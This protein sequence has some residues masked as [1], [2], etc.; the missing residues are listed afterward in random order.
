MKRLLN[1]LLVFSMVFSLFVVTTNE[2]NA[3]ESISFVNEYEKVGQEIK[4][5]TSALEGE[6]T[7]K[8]SVDGKAVSTEATYTPS[9]NDENK[10]IEV[11]VN[12]GTTDYVAKT[13]LSKLPVIYID[14][15][16]GATVTSKDVYLDSQLTMQGNDEWNSETT[17]L[18]VGASEIKGRGNST[19]GLPKKPY[20]LKF[21]KGIDLFGYGKSKHWVLLANYYDTTFLRNKIGY[22]LAG[23][24]DI[25][26]MQSILVD[27]VMNGEYVGNY[28]FCE[29]VRIDDERVEVTDW[30]GIG[31]DAAAAIVEANDLGDDALDELEGTMAENFSW[32]DTDSIQ[33]NNVTYKVSDYIEYPDVS[34]GY[35]LEMDTNYDEVSKFRTNDNVPIMFKGPEFANTS[36]SMMNYVK[37]YIQA[38]E[39]AV[40][41]PN[42]TAEHEDT[43]KHYTELFDMQSLVDNWLIQELFFN[44][45]FMK[46]STYMYKDHGELF[47]MGPVWDL[48]WASGAEQSA[49]KPYNQ[50]QTTYFN[51]DCQRDQWYKYMAKDPYFIKLAQERYLE[52]R[53]SYIVEMMND[54][55][56]YSEQIAVSAQK[57]LDIW[58]KGKNYESEMTKFKTWMNNRLEFL[59]DK[60]AD[61]DTFLN[62]FD[63]S[64]SKIEV[65]GEL[66]D[67]E[68]TYHYAAGQGTKLTLT[69]SGYGQKAEVWV[70]NQKVDE[71][72]A[73]D[74]KVSYELE[75]EE[76]CVV[77][78][79]FYNNDVL[80]SKAYTSISTQT[81]DRTLTGIEITAPTKVLY[82]LGEELDATGLLVKAIFDDGTYKYINDYTISGF[83]SQTI[84]EKE[85]T[86]NYGGFTQTFSV[87]VI[88]SPAEIHMSETDITIDTGDSYELKVT[89][90]NALQTDVTWVSDNVKVAEVYGGKVVGVSEGETTIRAS[91]PDGQTVTCKVTV[92]K[93]AS[94]MSD[95]LDPNRMEVIA[96]NEDYRDPA[97][98]VL[99]GNEASVWHTNWNPS[100]K[101]RDDHYLEFYLDE[102]A[103][104]SG[105]K[106]LP[107]QDNSN[108]GVIKT[109]NLYVKENSDEGAEWI[110]VVENGELSNSKDWQLVT[111]EATQASEIRLEVID[112]L[113][114]QSNVF[115]SAAEIRFVG[116]FMSDVD[117]QAL[118]LAFDTLSAVD[119]QEYVVDAY[120]ASFSNALANAKEVLDNQTATQ[121]EVDDAVEFLRT[122]YNNLTKRIYI[123]SVAFKDKEL[124]LVKSDVI[125]LEVE[126]NPENTTEDKTLTFVSSDD[127]VVRVVGNI[128]VAVGEGTA[129]VTV[130]SANGKTD[131][132]VITVEK[133]SEPESPEKPFPFEDVFKG[134]W[135][136]E[137]V[138]QAYQLGLMTGATETLF[139][140]TVSMN[141]GMVAIVLHRMEGS[142][143]VAYAPIFPDV[144]D[145]QYFTTAV[146]WAKQTGIITGYNNGT[147]MP[148]KNVT[149]EEMATMI[150]RFAKYK[151][152]DVSSSK[153]ITYF[154]DYAEIST[155]AKAPIE[156][157]VENG[158]LSGKFEGTKVD[159]LG[160][161]SRAECA[162]MLVQAYKVIYK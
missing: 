105:I 107:R 12:D 38:F 155:Y 162:K 159:P 83:D 59:D 138:D 130:T 67:N 91:L 93:S 99:D 120:L 79:Y 28:Q 94:D 121:K 103:V 118:Q 104:I 39:D 134:Q 106:L 49:A 144:Y 111:F 113:S 150:Q 108:N 11:I 112:A 54:I 157:C 37:T 116:S 72:E 85:V 100:T 8:W 128:A 145:K 109:F 153:D 41:A 65:S 15:E 53:D 110:K 31:E 3:A 58:R 64:M 25:P 9:A 71:V 81:V 86:V 16:N 1:I 117:K 69:A 143:K 139:K 119:T 34:G 6:L 88:D 122:A 148:L 17:K 62:E 70:N 102:P 29:H 142:E 4:V 61:F 97:E 126:I 5:D 40:K 92:V 55:D 147:F 23:D 90:V 131:T 50:W 151:G 89:L 20:R 98:N 51:A 115:S 82:K 141:R 137:Y 43:V 87:E 35:L 63:A 84:G 136:Y 10:F 154:K 57:T 78:F 2:V 36:K 75:V 132:C 123:E 56:T 74:G 68:T 161:A 125:T 152:L 133:Y 52:I 45:D 47:K 96:G 73:K 22:D 77:Q 32:I 18:Y 149:R 135:Y 129:T 13:F 33:Y 26:Y 160:T 156:W 146:M 14:I 66:S 24:M 27:L 76:N 30:E 114:D 124:E 44:E 101:E 48:D 42:Y 158:V 21:D 140:P 7:Y 46:K 95:V 19:W 127:S 80:V 60:I